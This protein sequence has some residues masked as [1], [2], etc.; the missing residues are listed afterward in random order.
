MSGKLDV[1]GTPIGNLGDMWER[2]VQTLTDVDFI[3]GEDTRVTSKLLSVLG[4]KKP[5][6]SYN[7]YNKDGRGPQIAD[8]L[9]SGESCAVVSDAGMPCISDPGTELVSLCTEL[10]IDIVSVPGPSAL[11]AALSVSG[12][13]TGRFAFE[14][15]LP[16]NRKNKLARLSEIKSFEHTLVFYEAPHKLPGTLLDMLE[17]LGDRRICI[18]REI[19][20]IYEEEIHT[21]LGEAAARYAEEPLKGEIVLIVE[22][23]T[24][25]GPQVS[26]SDA[27]QTAAKLIE[28]GLS[29][30][31][32]PKRVAA[33]TGLKKGDIYRTVMKLTE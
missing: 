12:M 28:Q 13:F 19:T 33:D 30:S 26:L 31:E 8:R 9:M 7:G 14:G 6:I 21:T 15:F 23:N 4:I 11:T 5:M 10:G 2:M 18:V 24:D 29:A 16:V 25:T 20:K 17:I 3:V 27:A 32:A 22:G 1:V